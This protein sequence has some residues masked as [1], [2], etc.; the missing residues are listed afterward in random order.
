VSSNPSACRSVWLIS[1]SAEAQTLGSQDKDSLVRAIIS[2]LAYDDES[3]DSLHKPIWKSWDPSSACV[4]TSHPSTGLLIKISFGITAY[5]IALE[6]IKVLSRSP[7]GSSH[8]S[9]SAGIRTLAYHAK[10]SPGDRTT[11][12][13][14]TKGQQHAVSAL[15]NTLLLHQN[16]PAL[17]VKGGLGDWALAELSAEKNE[18]PDQTWPFLMARMIMVLTS[19]ATYG[20]LERLVDDLNGL[21]IIKAVSKSRSFRETTI[22][23]LSSQSIAT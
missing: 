17:C 21:G 14:V 9:S 3:V 15:C 6:C 16:A 11:D 12:R 1:L 4:R 23:S 7:S 8:L 18:G 20:F 13:S 19:R 2:D 10:Y 22:D 5:E